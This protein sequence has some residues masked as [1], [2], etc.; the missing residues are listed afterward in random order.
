M[1]LNKCKQTIVNNR[2]GRK[3][4]K[5]IP[6][7]HVIN[8]TQ[9]QVARE[10]NIN[11]IYKIRNYIFEGRKLTQNVSNKEVI[12]RAVCVKMSNAKFFIFT[13]KNM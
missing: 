6:A 12:S 9:K 8:L 2:S 3:S 7:S 5:Q 11:M 13:L 4:R 1:L 10:L